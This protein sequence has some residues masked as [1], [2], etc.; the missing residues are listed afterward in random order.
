MTNLKGIIVMA[1]GVML[2]ACQTL[3]TKVGIPI[4]QSQTQNIVMPN[5]IISVDSE[6]D[7]VSDDSD[8]CPATPF[9]IKVDARSCPASVNLV[10]LLRMEFRAFFKGQSLSIRSKDSV[11]NEFRKVAIKMRE[12]PQSTAVVL[13]HISTI[14]AQANPQ[15]RLAHDRAQLVKEKLLEQGVPAQRI[16][17]FDCGDNQQLVANDSEEGVAMNQRVYVRIFRNDDGEYLTH[18]DAYN[19]QQF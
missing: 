9:H 19:C 4:E 11:D 18:K 2:S 7:G 14:E 1:S 15:N 17:T 8:E 3:P 5:A 12:F 10:G 6:A 16:Q 13:G